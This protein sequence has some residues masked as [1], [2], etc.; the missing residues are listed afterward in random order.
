MAKIEQRATQGV[1]STVDNLALQTILGLIKG[2]RTKD[3]LLVVKLNKCTFCNK[4]RV[5]IEDMEGEEIEEDNEQCFLCEKPVD[6]ELVIYTDN[7][8]QVICLM[9]EVEDLIKEQ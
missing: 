3:R 8:K 2:I 1:T 9:S 6:A 4:Q 5:Y 7:D